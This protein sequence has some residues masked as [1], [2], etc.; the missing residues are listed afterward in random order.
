M[1]AAPD[2]TTNSRL[3]VYYSYPLG[4]IVNPTLLYLY[5]EFPFKCAIRFDGEES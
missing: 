3:V 1:R 4:F 5:I 2:K